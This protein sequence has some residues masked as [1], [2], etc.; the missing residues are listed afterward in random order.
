MNDEA[1]LR[2]A[3]CLA[4]EDDSPR[5]M[6]A[7]W[8]AENGQEDHANF[9]RF[10]IV[11]GA[12]CN[13]GNSAN[14]DGNE[15]AKSGVTRGH[16][17]FASDMLVVVGLTAPN[18][19]ILWRRG[20]VDEIHLTLVQFMQHAQTIALRHPVRHWR[21]TD[22]MAYQDHP[23]PEFILFSGAAD[24]SLAQAQTGNIPSDLFDYLSGGHYYR[25]T[26]LRAYGCERDWQLDLQQACYQFARQK[27]LSR[28][29]RKG[30]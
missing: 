12:T 28:S 15:G 29:T 10:H 24:A 16:A 22:T 26:G 5:L 21:L 7:D 27:L 14:S 25:Y 1:G 18:D 23:H 2:R 13:A 4:P 3:I 30:E 20:F 19:R 17:S 11:S 6:L 9:I 8:L